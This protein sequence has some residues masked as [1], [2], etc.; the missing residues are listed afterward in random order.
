MYERVHIGSPNGWGSN[1]APSNGLSTYGGAWL[2]TNSGNVGIGTTS[3]SHK[4]HVNGNIF[5][6]N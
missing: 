4:L 3:P 6:N 5:L 1:N 2:A